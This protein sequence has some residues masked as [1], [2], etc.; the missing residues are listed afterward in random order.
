MKDDEDG[1]ARQR[2]LETRYMGVVREDMK[3]IGVREEDAE[4]GKR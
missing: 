2:D 3:L 1:T 4:D